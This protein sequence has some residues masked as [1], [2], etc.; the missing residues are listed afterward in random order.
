MAS[1]GAVR[2]RELQ[3][4][5]RDVGVGARCQFLLA[6]LVQDVSYDFLW[7]PVEVLKESE[8]VKISADSDRSQAKHTN[9]STCFANHS[10]GVTGIIPFAPLSSANVL[11]KSCCVFCTYS[12]H[13]V[14]HA[15]QVVP[16]RL[17]EVLERVPG[18][19]VVGEVHRRAF[20]YA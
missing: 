4:L 18:C 3:E 17:L 8:R 13:T 19:T 10:A 9:H 6:I 16:V 15:L 12:V 1:I 20:R 2:G 14:T 5:A 11:A 7:D